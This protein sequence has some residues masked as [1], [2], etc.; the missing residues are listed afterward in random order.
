MPAARQISAIT[1]PA[2]VG[3]RDAGRVVE[4]GNR[5]QQ[6]DPAT[7]RPT[8]LDRGDQR[9]RDQPVVVHRDVH[10]LRLVGVERAQRADVGR[11]LGQDDVAR[12]DE[13]AGGQVQRHLRADGDHHV[14][15]VGLDALERHHLADLFAQLRDALAGAVL[16]GDQARPR[17]PARRPRPPSDSS[18][19]DCRYGMPPAS[20]TTSGRLA[21]A[22]SARIAEAR[23]PAVRWAYRCMCWSRLLP[24]MSTPRS[25]CRCRPVADA[26]PMPLSG[27]R[28]SS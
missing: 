15:R 2:V 27:D 25:V 13:D 17:R 28:A 14:V 3:Q 6:L 22:N 4:V 20:D 21:T 5:V 24:V 7:G 18:G 16:Q 12:I 23:M 1:R 11:R 9:L 19:S 10:D 8:R 26:Q